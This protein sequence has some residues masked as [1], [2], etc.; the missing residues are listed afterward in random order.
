MFHFIEGSIIN[1]P[2]FAVGVRLKIMT[3][4]SNVS[5]IENYDT[6]VIFC[7]RRSIENYDTPVISGLPNQVCEFNWINSIQFFEFNMVSIFDLKL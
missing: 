7:G 1:V 6:P 4:Q 2:F 3:P 5:L